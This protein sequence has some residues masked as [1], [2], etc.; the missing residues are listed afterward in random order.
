MAEFPLDPQL[1]KMLIVS[2]DYKCSNEVLTIAAMLSV[3]N[4]FMR[5]KEYAREAD[6]A[7]MQFAHE[8]GDHLS[9]L[10]AYDAYLQNGSDPKWCYDNY[11]QSRHLRSATSVRT[12]LQQ[13]MVKMG[14]QLVSTPYTDKDYYTNIRKSIVAGFFMQIA[15]LERTGHYLTVKDNQVVSLHPS[16]VLDNKPEWVLYQE[17][18]LTSKNFVRTVTAVRGDWLVDIAPHYFELDNFPKCEAKQALERIY[19]RR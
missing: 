3:S 7:K 13:I 15:H 1:S 2:P 4:V 12:Q 8:H 10:N 11:L 17:F 19:K 14:L 6:E 18:V 16:T 9:L 5:P